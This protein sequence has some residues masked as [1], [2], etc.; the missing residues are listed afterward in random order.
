MRLRTALLAL[1][2]IICCN[3]SLAQNNITKT[4]SVNYTSGPPT[5]NPSQKTGSEFAIDTTNGRFYELHR[6]SSTTGVWKLIAQ[7][8]D[9]I[10]TTGP[11]TYIPTRNMSW[12]VINSVDSLYRYS[13]TPTIWNCINCSGGGSTYTSG[14]GISISIGNVISNTGDLS[15]TNEIQYP[16][17]FQIVS[18]ILR[19]SLFGDGIP[20][21]FVDLSA[22]ANVATDLTFTGSGPYTL[23]SST[24]TDVTFSQGSGITLTRTSNDLGIAAIDVSATNEIQRVDTFAI[25]SNILRISLLNDAVPF[26][27][28]D[29]S[30]YAGNGTVTDFSA[31]DLSPLFTTSEATTTTTPALSFTRINQAANLHYS[32]PA[33][34]GAAAPTFRALVLADIIGLNT[35]NSGLSD[36]EAGGG[37]FRLGN[38]YMNSSDG[39]FGTD[40][41][42]NVNDFRLFYGD[43]NDSTLLNIDGVNNGVGIHTTTTSRTLHVNGTVRVT[44]LTPGVTTTLMVGVDGSGDFQEV[45]VGSGLSLSGNTLTTSGGGGTFYQTLKANGTAATQQ[46]I[47]NFVNSTHLSWSLTNDG[48]NTETEVRASIIANSISNTEIRQG[49]AR[50]LIG[51]SGNAGANVADIQSTS[52]NQVMRANTGGTAIGWGNI[53]PA[54]ITVSANNVLIGNIAGTNQNAQELTQANLYTLLGMSGQNPRFAIWTGTNTLTHNAAWTHDVANGRATFTGTASGTGAGTGILNLSTG[55]LGAAT[56]FL[57]MRGTINSNL[58]AEMIN[59]STNTAGNSIFNIATVDAAG[60]PYIQYQLTGAGGIT[61]SAGID[62]TTNRWM[63]T[64]NSATVGAGGGVSVVVKDDAGVTKLS[65]GTDNPIQ[66]LT[67]EGRGRADLWMG[68]GN[69]YTS[70][71]VAFGTGAGTGP[72][73]NSIRGTGN[74]VMV[75][76]QTGTA[77]TAGGVIFTLTYPTSFPTLSMVVF[78]AG[79]DGGGAAGDNAAN[80]IGANLV[81]I[82]TSGT[83]TFVFKSNGALT[84]STGYAFTFMFNG[85]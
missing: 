73:I 75:N 52:A 8:I 50:S 7:G 43:N 35:A 55:T 82:E 51:V 63:I 71:N 66:P 21:K 57:S 32:G 44:N 81:K 11:P 18:N 46:P 30:A 65:V 3:L 56:T 26:S 48:P 33:S 76:F 22:Y 42:V 60:D 9:T 78:S 34:G 36:N 2:V 27:S 69:M 28:I 16:D 24:G 64:P 13:G 85:Y 23:N 31:G 47:E 37:V 80:A 15:N 45:T 29:L 79:I 49:V 10:E 41:K 59:S 38:R 77:P 6:T 61:F 40:R 70:A 74:S 20:F 58:I 19:L 84:A 54:A 5:F 72:A 14:T 25:V 39:A 62:N 4:A 67:V 68:E 12:F 1:L 17:T 53:V 83:T